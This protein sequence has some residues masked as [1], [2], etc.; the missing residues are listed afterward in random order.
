[1]AIKI[2]FSTMLSE[3]NPNFIRDRV[4]KY[5]P[6]VRMMLVFAMLLFVGTVNSTSD[7]TL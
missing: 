6:R 5:R 7:S 1:M 4:R 3:L 2:E